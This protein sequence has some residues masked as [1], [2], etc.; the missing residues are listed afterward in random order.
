M[1]GRIEPQYDRWQ[2]DGRLIRPASASTCI[3]WADFQTMHV[4]TQAAPF[5]FRRSETPEWA[6]SDAL[7]REV[8][9]AY[10]EQRAHIRRITG[11]TGQRLQYAAAALRERIPKMNAALDSLCRKYMEET[12]SAR[13]RALQIE[14]EGLDS[15][16]RVANRGPSVLA[17]VAYLY[18]RVGLCSADVAA[19][20]ELKPPHIRQILHRMNEI[21]E[22]LSRGPVY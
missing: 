8:I 7:L 22:E 17:A 15:A 18:F 5:S 6:L 12:D 2:F 14:I 21:A 20:L 11:T 13:K 16:I 9:V 10:L 3:S 1:R 19:E 4:N